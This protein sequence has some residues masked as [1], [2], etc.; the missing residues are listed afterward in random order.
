ML[1][2]PSSSSVVNATRIN[3][4]LNCFFLHRTQLHCVF[5]NKVL[6]EYLS[7]ILFY[8]NAEVFLTFL[9]PNHPNF[10]L[11]NLMRQIRM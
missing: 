4:G 6:L 8:L 11:L 1:L 7:I 3:R 9:Q 2:V 5:L 10:T